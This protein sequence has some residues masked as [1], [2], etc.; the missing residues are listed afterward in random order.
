MV[1]HCSTKDTYIIQAEDLTRMHTHKDFTEHLSIQNFISG[2][3]ES[4]TLQVC[5]QKFK[6]NK[7]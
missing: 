4:V 3:N 2:N 1:Y 6:S 7:T 5:Q